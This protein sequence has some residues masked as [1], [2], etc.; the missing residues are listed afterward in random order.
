VLPA[1]D[2][3]P[4]TGGEAPAAPV[5]PGPAAEPPAPQPAA[6][7]TVTLRS[8]LVDPGGDRRETPRKLT[9]RATLPSSEGASAPAATAP[10]APAAPIQ[11]TAPEPAI[12]AVAVTEA[13]VEEE[14]SVRGAT[15]TVRP[16]DSLWSIAKRLL[17]PGA[18]NGQIARKVER[19]WQLNEQRIATGDPSLLRVAT[20]LRLR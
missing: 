10:A 18:S 13:A 5:A 11:T 12:E 8:Q 1:E 16:G 9:L 7:E 17:G 14:A 4:L 6:P 15:Y 19:L 2:P 3:A 20:V